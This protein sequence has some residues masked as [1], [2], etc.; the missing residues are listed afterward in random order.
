VQAV[1]GPFREDADAELLDGSAHDGEPVMASHV[2]HP[3]VAGLPLG[4][5]S[6]GVPSPSMVWPLRSRVMLSAPMMMPL[7]GQLTRSLSSVVSVV[8]V[9]PQPTWL[10]SAWPPPTTVKPVTT[11]VRTIALA[12]TAFG[13][14]WTGTLMVSRDGTDSRLDIGASPATEPPIR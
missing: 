12:I 4:A 11:R 13:D 9:S 7:L 5:G 10:A 1:C 6:A 3:D 8:M 14:E 2:E